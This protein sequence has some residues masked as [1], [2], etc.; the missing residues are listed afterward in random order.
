LICPNENIE[1]HKVKIESH[2]GQSVILDQCS[3]CGGIW[4]D[5]SELYMAKQGKAD[6]IELLDA[7]NLRTP[8]AIDNCEL[9]CPKDRNKLVLFKDPYFPKDIIIVRCPVCEGFWLNRGEFTKYQKFR[10]SKLGIREITA[11]DEKLEQNIE[12]IL[13]NH[14][15]RGSVDTLGR[16]GTFLSTPLDQVTLRPQESR[17]LSDVEIN[18][19]NIIINALSVVL[20]LFIRI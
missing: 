5:K 17:H 19:F 11:I 13:E 18:A 7:N 20:R 16:L 3:S 15:S 6:Q 14:E 1:M 2:Y 8:S 9:L 12:R 4:F 10:Q